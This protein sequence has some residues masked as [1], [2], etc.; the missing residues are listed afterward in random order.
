MADKYSCEM[1]N[2][3]NAESAALLEELLE[4]HPFLLQALKEETEIETSN[5]Q[6]TQQSVQR[7]TAPM[8][9]STAQT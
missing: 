8:S 6:K 7:R 3:D 4:V 1:L 2:L 5:F 9:S